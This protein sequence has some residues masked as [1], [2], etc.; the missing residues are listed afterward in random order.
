MIK[1][2]LILSLVFLM[3]FSAS[4]CTNSGISKRFKENNDEQSE[5]LSIFSYKPDTFCPILSNNEANIRML[6]IIYDGLVFVNEKNSPLPILAESWS[7]SE[8]GL[9]WTVNL[10][11]NVSWHD[12]SLLSAKDVVY[13][14]KQIK[15]AE[16][17][18]YAYN[19]ANIESFEASGDLRVKF[20]LLEPNC[21]FINLL[22]FPIIKMGEE[23]IDA[24]NFKPI[25]TGPYAFEDR[26]EGNVYYLVKNK[27]WW[28]GEVKTNTIK[29]KMLPGGDTAL[30]AFG[31]S[32]IDLVPADTL[33]W[34]KFVD[35]NESSYVS[36]KTPIYNFWGINHS[37][38]LLSLN[39]IRR[40]ASLVIDRD[41][42]VKE[43][44]M[45]YGEVV[46][47]PMRPEWKLSKNQGFD[48]TK[49]TDLAKK[50]MEEAGWT[51]KDNLYRKQKDGVEYKAE[52]NILINEENTV[53]EN[54]AR[55]IQSRLQEFGIKTDI[56]RVSYDEYTKRINEGNY[57]T[58]LGSMVISPD[59]DF[60]NFLGEGNVFS[61]E[62][63]E[64]TFV[65]ENIK[66]K[67][68]DEEIKSAYA[69][70]INLF[71]QINPVIGLFFE[72]SVMLY[73]NRIIGK[74]NPSYFDIYSGIETLEKEAL[75]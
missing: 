4:A 60:S 37:S 22:Y 3:I 1:R 29:V 32:S 19:V 63:E 66:Q 65:M 42:I 59:L 75:E 21:N 27:K 52:F 7:S 55:L 73:S 2:F 25:G 58:F 17:S 48:L 47:S 46:N 61:F 67:R 23:E 33:D 15:K 41:E 62:D 10:R 30:Y 72:D 43:A 71:E 31:S 51:F 40:A 57:D 70:F 11:E 18:V 45:G 28:G 20:N 5:T 6:N 68:N 36:V 16:K 26:N 49:N 35:S 44:R 34:G 13:T 38:T 53:R 69:E 24:V 12:G 54:I 64:M 56:L 8:D 14:V 9:S 39:E 50:I 74:V